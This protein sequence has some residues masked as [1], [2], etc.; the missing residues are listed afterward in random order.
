MPAASSMPGVVTDE[1]SG[2]LRRTFVVDVADKRFQLRLLL[3]SSGPPEFLLGVSMTTLIGIDAE[4]LD[5]SASAS[6]KAASLKFT[7][8]KNGNFRRRRGVCVQ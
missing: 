2:K 7:P 6:V 1:H 3:F 8:L 4:D 5:S